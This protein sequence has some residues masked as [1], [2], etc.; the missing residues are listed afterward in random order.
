MNEGN[1]VDSSKRPVTQAGD[2]YKENA[3]D[4]SWVYV[5]R[6]RKQKAKMYKGG[7]VDSSRRPMTEARMQRV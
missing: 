5:S 1:D 2:M 3:A 7:A 4:S 6:A